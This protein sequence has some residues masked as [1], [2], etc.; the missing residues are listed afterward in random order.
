M[1]RPYALS[2]SMWLT[3]TIQQSEK[4]KNEIQA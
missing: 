1:L 3:V 2:W 4:K